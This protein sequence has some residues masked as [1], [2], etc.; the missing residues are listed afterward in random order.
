VAEA[1][2]RE[3]R[4]T[5][6]VTETHATPP[7][8]APVFPPGR[9]GRRRSAGRRRPWLVALLALGAIAVTSL[10]AVRLY[11]MY[12]NPHYDATVI[13]YTDVTDSQMVITFRVTVPAGESA[14]CVLRARARDGAVVGRAD[15]RVAAPSSDTTITSSQRVPTS[16]KAFVG[17]VLRCRPAD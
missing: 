7:S 13:T 5:R 9:Y 16:R 10:I 2:D 11:Q 1:A 4:R 12:G 14:T 15:V 6:Q 8:G 17:E 3:R